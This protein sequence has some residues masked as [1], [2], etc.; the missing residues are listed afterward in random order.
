MEKT[1]KKKKFVSSKSCNKN[2]IIIFQ[3]FKSAKECKMKDNKINKVRLNFRC[4]A[5]SNQDFR[6]WC[7]DRNFT[8]EVSNQSSFLSSESEENMWCLT[9]LIE[10]LKI[11][12]K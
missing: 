1:M 7:Y 2:I 5:I 8:G 4:L 11:S 3:K 6:Q 9:Y 10:I 12:L